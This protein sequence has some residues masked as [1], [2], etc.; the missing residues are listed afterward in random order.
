MKRG[1]ALS[2]LIVVG[3]LSLALQAARPPQQGGQTPAPMVVEVE[4]LKDNLFILR[5]TGGGGNTAVFVQTNGVTVVDTKN[6]G[7]GQPVLAKIRELTSK[8][9]TLIINTHTHGD[10]VSGNVAFPASV[11]ILTHEN[12]KR[13]MSEWKPYYGRTEPPPNVFKG[14][15]GQGLPKRTFKDRM[16][17]GSGSDQIDLYYFGRGHTDGD[18]WVVFPSLRTVHA[19]DIF[20]GKNLPFLDANNGG[21]GVAIGDS[22]QKAHDTIKNVDTI[23]TGHSGQMTWADLAQYAAFNR[24]FLNDVRTAMKA[25]KAAADVSSTWKIPAKYTGYTAPM[26]ERLRDNV[27][28]VFDEL[29]A[30]SR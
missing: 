3:T 16:T 6:P 18:A 7:W 21:S 25:G 12:T 9:V 13:R 17:I 26:P 24:E 4:K 27:Q 30:G 8:P 2:V 11:D 29:K 1:I 20:S 19:G 15:N 22:L 5:G 10:H 14:S 23:V 28:V